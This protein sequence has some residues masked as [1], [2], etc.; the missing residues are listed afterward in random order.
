[1][2]QSDDKPEDSHSE[3]FQSLLFLSQL[4]SVTSVPNS[5]PV[6]RTLPL[7]SHFLPHF[8]A[9]PSQSHLRVDSGSDELS[10]RRYRVGLELGGYESLLLRL[11]LPSVLNRLS[12]RGSGKREREGRWWMSWWWRGSRRVVNDEVVRV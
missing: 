8:F 7:H 3:Y 5:S 9:P 4:P 11:L 6:P 12:G 2:D 10:A 1:M